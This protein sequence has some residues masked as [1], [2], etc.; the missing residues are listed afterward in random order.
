MMQIFKLIFSKYLFGN[1]KNKMFTDPFL[2]EAVKPH[3]KCVLPNIGNSCYINS[4]M[5]IFL[6]STTLFNALM[7]SFDYFSLEMIREMYCEQNNISIAEQCDAVL[8]MCFLL[9]TIEERLKTKSIEVNNIWKQKWRSRLKCNDCKTIIDTNQSEHYWIIYPTEES[10]DT[11][12]EMDTCIQKNVKASV[13]KKCE[14]CS[15][16]KPIGFIHR[17]QLSNAPTNLFMNLQHFQKKK[18]NVYPNLSLTIGN[19]FSA[20]Y[21]LKGVIVHSGTQNF[22]HYKIYINIDNEWWLFS[23]TISY[24]IHQDI[25]DVIFSR[26]ITTPL[27]WY[28]R[29]FD[30][31]ES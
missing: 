7:C 28:E 10:T 3:T 29:T 1:Q 5:Q 26:H 14:K 27:L 23:D 19:D 2:S 24:K 4:V 11:Q 21:D 8:F 9:D 17:M 20:N 15:P 16:N 6:N 13:E 31:F 12:I 18:I 30:E 25:E 22:G